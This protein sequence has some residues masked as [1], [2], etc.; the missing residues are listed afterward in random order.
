MSKQNEEYKIGNLTVKIN[1]NN[2]MPINSD[3]EI[4]NWFK[5]EVYSKGMLRNKLIDSRNYDPLP[6]LT[7]RAFLRTLTGQR[8][9]IT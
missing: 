7:I 1:P 4:T 5:I 6:I 3:Q 8:A 9:Q 2:I